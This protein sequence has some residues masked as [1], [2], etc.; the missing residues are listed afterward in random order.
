VLTG[1]ELLIVTKGRHAVAISPDGF[2]LA[3]GG[4]DCTVKVW[5]AGLV[6]AAGERRALSAAGPGRLPQT[7][8][9]TAL[10]AVGTITAVDVQLPDLPAP[11]EP[12]DGGGVRVLGWTT[13]PALVAGVG[14]RPGDIHKPDPSDSRFLVL[15]LSV[16]I[17][18]LIPSAADYEL[19]EKGAGEESAE[20]WLPARGSMALLNPRR[21]VLHLADGRQARG[22]YYAPWPIY[23]QHGG[24]FTP[25]NVVYTT[26]GGLDPTAWHTFG[27]AWVVDPADCRLP[28]KVG[29]GTGGALAVPALRLEPPPERR[30]DE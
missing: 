21:F 22:A 3:T 4:D 6:D 26:S 1:Q 10:K 2:R 30:S 14:S 27:I 23:G 17:R 28:L 18:Q 20:R 16:R 7:A 25:K 24:G 11:S 29:F 8:G 12:A 13:A 5:E 15:V 19:L 9:P